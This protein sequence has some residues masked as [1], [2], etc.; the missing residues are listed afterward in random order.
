MFAD[1]SRDDPQIVPRTYSRRGASW[2][3]HLSKEEMDEKIRALVKIEHSGAHVW[4][5][6]RTCEAR[7]SQQRPPPK[8]I[9]WENRPE[10]NGNIID[11]IPVVG[12]TPVVFA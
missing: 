7:R 2:K 12:G 9:T 5:F 6:L 8:R 11:L 3:V 4:R 1:M 10:W